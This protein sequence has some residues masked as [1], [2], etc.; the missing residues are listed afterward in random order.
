MA[1]IC[2]G[3]NRMAFLATLAHVV[4]VLLTNLYTLAHGTMIL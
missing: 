4:V 2:E 3:S 1:S